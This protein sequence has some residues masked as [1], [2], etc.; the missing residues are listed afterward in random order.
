MAK[1]VTQ[2]GPVQIIIKDD[3]AHLSAKTARLWAQISCDAGR[4]IAEI[5]GVEEVTEEDVDG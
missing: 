1:I 5:V 3:R 4:Q 2:V